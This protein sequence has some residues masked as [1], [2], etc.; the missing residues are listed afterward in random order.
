M[1]CHSR[2]NTTGEKTACGI[3]I[4]PI[5]NSSGAVAPKL[6][7]DGD[8]IIDEAIKFFRPNLLFKNYDLKGKNYLDILRNF[9]IKK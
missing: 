8:D 4:A 9:F 3:A 2:F 7:G 6:V 1:A 5:K